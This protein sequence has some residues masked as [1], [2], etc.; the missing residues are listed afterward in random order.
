MA[1]DKRLGTND[2]NT[3][4][5]TFQI[6]NWNKPHRLTSSAIEDHPDLACV[7]CS[8]GWSVMTGADMAKRLGK[9]HLNRAADK[10]ALR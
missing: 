3:R 1:T 6:G 9:V 10:A 2:M 4:D 5:A 7:S 8:C